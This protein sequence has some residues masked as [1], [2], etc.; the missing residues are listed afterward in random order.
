MLFRSDRLSLNGRVGYFKEN[1]DNGKVG[2]LNDTRWTSYSGGMRL[3]LPGGDLQARAYGDVQHAHYNFLAVT[4]A[5]T[6][7]NVVRLATDQKLPVKGVGGMA[8]WQRVFGTKQAFTLGTDYRWV[9]G[10]SQESAYVA[11]TPAAFDGVTQAATLSVQR[12]SG[13]SQRSQGAFVQD[14]ITPTEKLVITLN[15]RIDHWRNYAGHNNEKIGRAH[16]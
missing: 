6:T 2:E 16:V 11:S 9:E 10:E 7:R 8:Q 5:A 13:G 4:N 14:V 3:E 15:A 12:Y 1:R